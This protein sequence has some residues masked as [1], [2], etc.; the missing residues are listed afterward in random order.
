[1]KNWDYP[2]KATPTGTP[3]KLG[4]V[5]KLFFTHTSP[6]L[7]GITLLASI[8]Y[9]IYLGAGE[10]WEALIPLVLVAFW[11]FLEWLIHVFILHRKPTKLGKWTIDL[12]NANKH[13]AHHRDP[14]RTEFIF[15]PLFASVPLIPIIA[16]LCILLFP[17]PTA[18]ATAFLSFIALSVHY[19]WVHMIAHTQWG[20]KSPWA[21][22]VRDHQLH[23]FKNENYW[24]GVSMTLG[25]KILGTSPD[26]AS[27]EKSETVRTLGV[28][29]PG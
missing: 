8:I 29:V 14:W 4:G 26:P 17:T 1:M 7:L 21:R 23:H 18:A 28:S 12:A 6:Q 10:W 22:V 20:R 5:L 13:R 15:V 9:R 16:G 27:V 19:E 3:D 2:D 24:L 11:P 25:D